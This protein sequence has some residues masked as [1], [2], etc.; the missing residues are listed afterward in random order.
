[1]ADDNEILRTVSICVNGQDLKS[2]EAFQCRAGHRLVSVGRLTLDPDTWRL[3]CSCGEH[4]LLT[5]RKLGEHH[6]GGIQ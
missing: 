5:R 4:N 3:V 1:M 2:G 6:P